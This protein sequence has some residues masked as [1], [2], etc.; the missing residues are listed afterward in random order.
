MA[1]VVL[2]AIVVRVVI[3]A[4]EGEA[5][6]ADRNVSEAMGNRSLFDACRQRMRNSF[7]KRDNVSI[8]PEQL[9]N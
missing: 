4:D 5:V 9:L 6:T 2:L 1:V 7:V 3:L 8:R